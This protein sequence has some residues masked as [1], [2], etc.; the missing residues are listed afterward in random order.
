M[1]GEGINQELGINIYTVL[2]IRQIARKD[3]V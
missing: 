1:S 2:Y 3:T